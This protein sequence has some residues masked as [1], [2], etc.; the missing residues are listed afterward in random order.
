MVLKVEN[1]GINQAHDEKTVDFGLKMTLKPEKGAFL[2]KSRPPNA[3][4]K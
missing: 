4:F 2:A 3:G 1:R